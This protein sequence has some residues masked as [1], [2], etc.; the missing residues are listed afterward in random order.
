[1]IYPL[2]MENKL[3]LLMYSEGDVVKKIEVNV[4]QQELGE[5][6]VQFRKLLQSPNSN[7]AEVQAT[8]AKLYNWLIKPLEAELKA[9]PIKHLVFSLDRVT[10][11]IPM[12]ALFDGQKR[13]CTLPLTVNLCQIAQISLTF[14]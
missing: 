11:Y 8:S 7:I 2:V 6:V 12:S 10:R 13:F 3:W 5:T 9:N 14:C 1:M 4:G